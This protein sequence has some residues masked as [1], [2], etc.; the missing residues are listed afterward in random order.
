MV[1]PHVCYMVGFMVGITLPLL[2]GVFIHLLCIILH[3]DTGGKTMTYPNLIIRLN[4]I[5][6]NAKH[7]TNLCASNGVKVCGIVKGVHSEPKVAK[8]MV[9]GGVAQIGDARIGNLKRLKTSGVNVPLLLTRIPMVSE[10]EDVVQYADI[11]LNSEI[12]TIQAINKICIQKNK[13]HAVVL[14]C[15]LGDL[16]EG[17]IDPQK[18]LESSIEI[19]AMQGVTL[20]G[21][22]TNLGCYGS[23]KPTCKNLGDLVDL[24][25]TIEEKIGRTLDIISGGASSSLPL[26]ID[27]CMPKRVNHLRIGESILLARD[28]PD[29][30]KVPL[31]GTHQN[32][33]VIEA[34]IVEIK[35]KP[36]HP[37]GDIFIDAFG[38]TPSY[39][40]RGW[41]TRAIVAMGRQDFAMMDQ[42]LPL[43][44]GIDLVGCSSD[45][46][47]VSISKE[48]A[49]EV[50][51]ILQ[52][53]MYYGPMLFLSGADHIHKTYV[54]EIL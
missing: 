47:I 8:A 5:K 28:L 35:R 52:F 26:L 32:T 3:N 36:S 14:M 45:H 33:M 12:K 34:E 18:L 42:L 43:D 51:D 15:D 27:G 19:E 25:E 39:E 44:Q 17:F 20:A 23:I 29:L 48:R 4:Y 30:W 1:G 46:L 31:P 49:Y 16:R 21:L 38:N 50:G 13:K 9:Q 11:S 22:G 7:I 53:E 54:T 40:D 6:E 10:I 2:D 41:E 24:A 37:I